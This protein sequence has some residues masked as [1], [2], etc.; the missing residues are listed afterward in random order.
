MI[1]GPT[2]AFAE[3]FARALEK[4]AKAVES[5]MSSR[6]DDAEWSAHE[7]RVRTLRDVAAACRKAAGAE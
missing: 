7:T 2:R 1:D 3:A 5:E 6:L 4:S